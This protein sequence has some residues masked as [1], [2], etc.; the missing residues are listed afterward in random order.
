M[1]LIHKVKGEDK[2]FGD[3]TSLIYAK[4]L[5]E[6]SHSCRVDIVFDTYVDKSIKYV[7][8][9]IRGSNVGAIQFKASPPSKQLCNGEKF[10]Q[11]RQTRPASFT[12]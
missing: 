4:T 12:Y 9:E 6:A 10:F 8:R 3:I 1:S 11:Q 5:N 2:T 7:E